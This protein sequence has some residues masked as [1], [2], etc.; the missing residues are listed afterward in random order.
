M[1]SIMIVPL[2]RMS[3]NDFV[4]YTNYFHSI[5]LI[6]TLINNFHRYIVLIQ[7]ITEILRENGQLEITHTF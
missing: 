2:L 3:F 5:N 7:N 4:C 1:S 6:E